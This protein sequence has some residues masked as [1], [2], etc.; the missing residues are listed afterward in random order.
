MSAIDKIAFNLGIRNE[1][2]NQD[3][4]RELSETEDTAGIKEI[5]ENLFN[6]NKNISSDCIKVMYE[7][8]YINPA[9]IEKY[10]DT[11]IQLLSSRANRMVWGAMIALS[12]VAELQADK[13]FKSA[14]LIKSIIDNGTVITEVAGLKTLARIAS[15]NDAYYKKIFSYLL[16]YIKNGR[17]ID[18]PTRI[19]A[20]EIIMNEKNAVEIVKALKENK[21]EL[22]DIQKKRINRIL[23]KY[24]S[25]F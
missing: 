8:G 11:F 25:G 14:G 22:K 23:K 19:E 6:K 21:N 15:K 16:G 10:T 20:Y 7:I 2:P 9:L 18:L 24:S 3:L 4:A 13:I 5:S 17:P 12:T 1:V